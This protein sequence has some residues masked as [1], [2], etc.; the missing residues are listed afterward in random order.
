[1]LRSVKALRSCIQISTCV[2]V[3][4][5]A[6][7]TPL[8][9]TSVYADVYAVDVQVSAVTP[10][11]SAQPIDSPLSKL[12][13]FTL[14]EQDL[15]SALLELGRQANLAI[16]GVF[17]EL[18]DRKSPAIQARLSVDDALKILLRDTNVSFEFF[19]PNG[20]LL[21]V[22]RALPRWRVPRSK[23]ATL[24]YDG[25][26]EELSVIG[27]R[28]SRPFNSRRVSVTNVSQ[29]RLDEG[30]IGNI[31]ELMP[32][33][34]SLVVAASSSDQSD[35]NITIRGV[36][37]SLSTE[38][39][40]QTVAVYI[41]GVALARPQAGLSFLYD[42]ESVDVV[43]GPQGT[44]SGRSALAGA[45]FLQTKKPQPEFSA[46][47]GVLLGN[48]H[49][50]SFSGA[51]N[52]PVHERFSMRIAAHTDSNNGWVD[53]LTVDPRLPLNTTE[54]EQ[55][56]EPQSGLNDTGMRAMRVSALVKTSENSDWLLSYE[57]LNNN[58][59]GPVLLNP[60]SVNRGDFSAYIDNLQ[61]LLLDSEYWRSSWHG[62]W[63]GIEL[64]Y[65][66]GFSQMNRRQGVDVDAGIMAGSWQNTTAYQTTTSDSHELAFSGSFN[67]AIYW[68]AGAIFYTEKTG[69]DFILD[70]SEPNFDA[71]FIQPERG[72]R[73]QAI[74]ANAEFSLA[75]HLTL[76]AG[77]RRS[78]DTKFDRGGRNY[79][80][81]RDVDVT[82]NPR[83]GENHLVF[84]DFFNNA[85]GNA[86]AG[87]DGLDDLTDER[88]TPPNFCRLV[89]INDVER[90]TRYTSGMLKLAHETDRFSSYASI[91]SAYQPGLIVDSGA[92]AIGGSVTDPDELLSYELGWQSRW[93]RSTFSMAAFYIDYLATT[94]SGFDERTEVFGST[95]VDAEIYGIEF[96][97]NWHFGS[98]GQFSLAGSRL[99]SAYGDYF[100]GSGACYERSLTD[101]GW[102]NLQGNDLPR[103]PELSFNVELRWRFNLSDGTLTPRFSISYSDDVYFSDINAVP[104]NI[105]SVYLGEPQSGLSINNPN[106]QEA[107]TKMDAGLRYKFREHDISVDIFV[108]NLTEK[109]T[110]YSTRPE[111]VTA[112]GNAARYDAPRAFGVRLDLGY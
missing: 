94:R 101:N 13:D 99:E 81:C 53:A 100:T 24:V 58:A 62:E 60:E 38:V 43:R 25:E 112:S 97:L 75:D 95:S 34:P 88:L 86:L 6:H 106:G 31:A 104:A 111:P 79:F 1:M 65:L 26:F 33:V 21:S 29:L 105:N 90:T 110:K 85:T 16:V 51:V 20:V 45:M 44:A 108:H 37:A 12:Y 80:E 67:P 4:A 63:A 7:F 76:T 66:A 22:K 68:K 39:S 50:R 56:T 107:F 8:S 109:M 78:E 9:V 35:T 73:S 11:E 19:E 28:S 84:E 17:T 92:N 32:L 96:D 36:G 57:S 42:M 40:D 87:G 89:N 59:S 93:G 61:Y 5:A 91:A 3:L 103:A 52:I 71:R 55:S 15:S 74:Y 102:C 83:L 23:E 10:V 54:D 98:G 77:V 27:N 47:F 18:T 69:T 46:D 64:D 48:Y 49:R 41:D 82:V 70:F 2:V 72:I 30:S 14:P